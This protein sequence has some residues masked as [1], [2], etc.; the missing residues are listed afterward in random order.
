MRARTMGTAGVATL[1]LACVF[2]LGAG[3]RTTPTVE[4][5]ELHTTESS[6]LL[7]RA[8]QTLK[9]DLGSDPLGADGRDGSALIG[10]TVS[11]G[12]NRQVYFLNRVASLGWDVIDVS[13]SGNERVYTLRRVR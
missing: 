1:M 4:Y 3:S 7:L 6:G 11:G 10:R 13:V 9:L 5:A 2:A 12:T 8:G